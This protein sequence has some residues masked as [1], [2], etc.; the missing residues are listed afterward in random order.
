[1]E[2]LVF[3]P[4][5]LRLCCG[6]CS[7]FQ[8]YQSRIADAT[9]ILEW[10]QRWISGNRMHWWQ[11]LRDFK[12]FQN[13][14]EERLPSDTISGIYFEVYWCPLFFFS[15]HSTCSITN[16]HLIWNNWV[17]NGSYKWTKWRDEALSH[18]KNI[19]IV[20]LKRDPL[21]PRA[22]HMKK[23]NKWN[24]ES[25]DSVAGECCGLERT[26]NYQV[27]VLFPITTLKPQT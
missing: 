27:S 2:A 21:T 24:L 11:L 8:I 4:R 15:F 1:M 9:L 25:L 19:L 17:C 16:R 6:K 3:I 13:S 20:F 10:W 18:W 5:G 22:L 23:A 14:Q 7:A 26:Q 12:T